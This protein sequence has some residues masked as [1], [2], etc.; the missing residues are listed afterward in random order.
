[1]AYTST[2]VAG[3]VS[4]DRVLRQEFGESA[5]RLQFVVT[6]T[7]QI[8]LADSAFVQEP[9]KHVPQLRIAIVVL[10]VDLFTTFGQVMLQ[11][12]QVL[13][14]F[15]LARLL[16]CFLYDLMEFPPQSSVESFAGDG[17]F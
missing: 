12:P 7:T 15:D 8:F 6:Q 10:A 4:S 3:A 9:P 17:L 16:L 13:G 1:M 11:I 2:L 5:D 14:F